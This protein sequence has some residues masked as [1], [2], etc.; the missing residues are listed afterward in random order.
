LLPCPTPLPQAGSRLFF[1]L[2]DL[3]ALGAMYHFALPAF[4][5]LF[6]AALR[7]ETP[8]AS[9]PARISALRRHLVELVYAHAARWV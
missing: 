3:P 5:A 6:R 8:A 9:V 4:M 1:L 2:R 7:L